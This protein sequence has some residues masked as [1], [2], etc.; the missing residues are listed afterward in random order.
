MESKIRTFQDLNLKI[1][2]FQDLN[3]KIRTF[4]VLII[5]LSKLRTFQE[6]RTPWEPWFRE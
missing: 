5:I 2:T 1:R 3:L 4:K 6:I